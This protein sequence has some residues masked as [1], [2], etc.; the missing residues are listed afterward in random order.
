MNEERE[1]REERIRQRAYRLWEQEG[2]PEGQ[3]D[4]YWTRAEAQIDAEGGI[5]DV[6]GPALDQSAGHGH[7]VD[8]LIDDDPVPPAEAAREARRQ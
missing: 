4:E 1:E 8:P 5:D 2:S 6:P 3:A 7:E